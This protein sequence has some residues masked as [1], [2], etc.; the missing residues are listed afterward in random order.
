MQ[1][2]A[3]A[4]VAKGAILGMLHAAKFS[5]KSKRCKLQQQYFLNTEQHV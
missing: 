1:G 3:E 2:T 5:R 4:W